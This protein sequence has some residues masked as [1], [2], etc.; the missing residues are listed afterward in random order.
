MEG[1]AGRKD[2][3]NVYTYWL[4]DVIEYYEI[5]GVKFLIPKSLVKCQQTQSRN[6]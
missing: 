2:C 6:M 1:C 4:Y 5:F 3:G